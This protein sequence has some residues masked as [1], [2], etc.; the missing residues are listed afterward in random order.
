MDGSLFITPT[1]QFKADVGDKYQNTTY[2]F[3]RNQWESPVAHFPIGQAMPTVGVRCNPILFEL[4]RAEDVPAGE[5]MA[6]PSPTPLVDLP[7]RM[8]LAVLSTNAIMLYDTQH[9][10]MLSI[11]RNQHHAN[12][13]DVAWSNDGS[14]LMVASSDGFCSVVEFSNNEL[15]IP[16]PR[17]KYP[18][19][20]T[21]KI[22]Q[23][24]FAL[25]AQEREKQQQ[26]QQQQQ[27][28]LAVEA[29]AEVGGNAEKTAVIGK[30]HT[31]SDSKGAAAEKR[32]ATNKK[33]RVSLMAV[34]QAEAATGNLLDSP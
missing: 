1:G 9:S 8:V 21:E 3:A 27:Q 18:A 16:L 20:M 29:E 26:K 15:G 11:I 31:A 33:R 22:V 17:D 14:T 7:Y 34:S 23:P 32:G 19:T 24:W 12:L 25:R 2:L 30:K 5:E 4:R 10:H 28:Q 13:T 6:P